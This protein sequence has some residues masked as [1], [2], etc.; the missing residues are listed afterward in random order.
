MLRSQRWRGGT[1][2]LA[3]VVVLVFVAWRGARERP[4]TATASVT[5]A[6]T[7]G[8]ARTFVEPVRGES[9]RAERTASA[10]QAPS[11]EPRASAPPAEAAE[12]IEIHG[13]LLE[14]ESREPVAGAKLRFRTDEPEG[15]ARTA[16]STT[17]GAI[18]L[19]LSPAALGRC[20]S[21]EA[22]LEGV[23]LF[24]GL[25]R[26]EDGF[27]LLARRRLALHGVV[28]GACA[29]C[30]I[31]FAAERTGAVTAELWSGATTADA[32]GRF[33]IT[34]AVDRSP[35]AFTLRIACGTA[36]VAR[37]VV[38][39]RELESADGARIVLALE[40][41]GFFVH[42]AS[43]E[44][45]PDAVIRVGACRVASGDDGGQPLELRTDSAGRAESFAPDGPLDLCV[46]AR[47]FAPHVERIEPPHAQREITLRALGE[48]EVVRGRVELDSGTPVAD[49]YVS[50]RPRSAS[51]EV[52]V[53]SIVGVRTGADGGFELPVDCSG[54]LVLFASHRELGDSGEV[55]Y[56][57]DGRPIVLVI[58]ELGELE[59]D[60][61][62]RDLHGPF[63]SGAFECVVTSRSGAGLDWDHSWSLPLVFDSIPPGDGVVTVVARGLDVVG[64]AEF[65]HLAGERTRVVVPLEPARWASGRLRTANGAA[66]A[67]VELVVEPSAFDARLASRSA[68]DGSFRVL[69]DRGEPAELVVRRDG[70]ALARFA[71]HAGDVGALA[72]EADR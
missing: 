61:D 33:A 47:G 3:L 39:T 71:L 1:A 53:P 27:V 32:E 54:P 35:C 42:D 7:D 8:S 65:R 37:R 52:S 12:R 26:L 4:D 68:S 24:A 41:L 46:G 23:P 72:V 13:R 58:A 2:V 9:E 70:A 16:T 15:E 36:L 22:T 34:A 60:V 40:R 49:A 38:P 63:A 17:D 56:Q 29:S 14:A 31:S 30:W 11:R 62:A 57:P 64:H 25:A 48:R 69:L 59:V 67:N 6:A 66:L 5:T 51:G 21:V 44:P 28:E 18:A 43:G 45:I 55:E 20:A 10:S 50:A 19:A